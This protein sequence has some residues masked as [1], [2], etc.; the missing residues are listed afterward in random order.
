M[1]KLE[2]RGWLGSL[3]RRGFMPGP[4]MSSVPGGLGTV[5]GMRWSESLA[6]LGKGQRWL[7]LT[8]PL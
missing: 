6:D 7:V 3:G 8:G 2:T 4:W 5:W 1:I